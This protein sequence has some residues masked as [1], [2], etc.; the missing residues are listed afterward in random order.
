MQRA[1]IRED[2]RVWVLHSSRAFLC[3]WGLLDG[4]L[5]FPD[6]ARHARMGDFEQRSLVESTRSW[7]GAWGP[8][9]ERFGTEVRRSYG[10]QRGSAKAVLQRHARITFCLQNPLCQRRSP[11]TRNTMTSSSRSSRA[12]DRQESSRRPALDR[13]EGDH[14]EMSHAATCRRSESMRKYKMAKKRKH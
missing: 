11:D 12:G 3:F 10:R 13:Q 5:R 1:S 14:Q 8:P 9:Y 4:P 2:D 7:P 6:L